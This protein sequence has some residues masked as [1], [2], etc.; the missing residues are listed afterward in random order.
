M[1]LISK[2]NK[3]IRLLLC[4]IDTYNKYA[5][6]IPL[7]DKKGVTI[8]SA[9]QNVLND[10]MRKPDKIWV[11]KGSEFYNRW[12][13]LWLKDNVIEMYSI[14]N[15]EKSVV[16]KRFIRTLKNKIYKHMT[17]VSKNVYIDKLNDIVNEYNHTYHRTIKMKPVDV[18]LTLVKR[19]M[20]KILDLKLVIK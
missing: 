20:I 9:F 11:D 12:M 14:N 15:E 17:V 5:W 3:R 2:F 1:Q 8:V 4:V 6:V 19:L 13:K 18:V 16:A 7:K 10:S